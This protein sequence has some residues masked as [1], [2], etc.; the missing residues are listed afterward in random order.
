[1]GQTESEDEYNNINDEQ[2][3]SDPT[4]IK[5]GYLFIYTNYL[6]LRRLR[7]VVLKKLNNNKYILLTYAKN[8]DINAEETHNIT[9]LTCNDIKSNIDKFTENYWFTLH[10]NTNQIIMTLYSDKKDIIKDWI[11]TLEYTIC[12]CKK[13]KVYNELQNT[14]TNINKVLILFPRFFTTNSKSLINVV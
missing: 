6:Q 2:I 14:N 9:N 7:R 8:T 11:T 13:C 3:K 12:Q 5:E 10:K 1:M 4:V